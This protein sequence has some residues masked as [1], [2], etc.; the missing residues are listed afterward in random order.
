MIQLFDVTK[1]FKKLIAVDRVN[2][3]IRRGESVAILGAN[4]AGKSTLIKCILGL[5]DYEGIIQI[6]N[7]DIKQS[8]KSSKSLIG[9]VPQEPIFY[10]MKTTDIIKKFKGLRVLV[11]G[12]PMLDRYV[13]GQVQRVSPEAPVPVLKVVEEFQSPGGAAN[14]AL[15]LK[16]LGSKVDLIGVR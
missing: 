2:L 1:K 6:Q 11:L 7:Q 14:V 4:G 9:Y 13:T 12:D 3:S 15:N 5:L 8:L 16:A 10:D